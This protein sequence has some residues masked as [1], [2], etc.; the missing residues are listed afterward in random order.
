MEEVNLQGIIEKHHTESR[1]IIAMMQDIQDSYNYL[2]QSVLEEL[3]Q[4]LDIPLSRAYSLA[5]F[6]KAFSLEPKGKYTIKVCTG[7]A[8]H[9]RGAPRII[10]KFE[11]ELDI[12]NGETTKDLKFSLEEVRCLGCCG[13][14]PVVT[15]GND[16]YGKVTQTRV[17]S[18]LKKYKKTG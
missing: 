3:C 15:V 1:S 6:Y 12:K 18:I 13:L 17:P 2:P 8:C 14:A 10:E 16:L 9:V 7:T 4:K 5:T 11:R